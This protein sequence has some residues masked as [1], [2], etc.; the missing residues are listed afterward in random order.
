MPEMPLE[1]P[2]K[3]KLRETRSFIV[4]PRARSGKICLTSRV[5][6]SNRFLALKEHSVSIYESI[7][8]IIRDL[9]SE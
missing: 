7:S 4:S 1:P 6:D 2:R 3:K 5:G 9:R 8:M